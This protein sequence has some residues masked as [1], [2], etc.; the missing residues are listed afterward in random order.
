MYILS[1]CTHIYT[2]HCKFKRKSKKEEN[3]LQIEK[4]SH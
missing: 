1:S 3:K 4:E 2:L